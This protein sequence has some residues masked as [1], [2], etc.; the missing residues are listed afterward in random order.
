MRLYITTIRSIS[1]SWS[2]S[3][4]R[5]E[6]CSIVI[7]NNHIICVAETNI[8]MLCSLFYRTLTT[9]V[10]IRA[11]KIYPL[12]TVINTV[13]NFTYFPKQSQ[14]FC[15]CSKQII[16]IVD[17]ITCIIYLN[18]I[19]YRISILATSGISNCPCIISHGV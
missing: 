5:L 16:L 13:I 4:T 12:R 17:N 15:Q 6:Y 9:C 10:A 1:Y 7:R 11:V 3:V 18:N 19:T 2:F 8:V 14:L